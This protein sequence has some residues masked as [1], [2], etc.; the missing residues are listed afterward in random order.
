MKVFLNWIKTIF[1][2]IGRLVVEVI[3]VKIVIMLV[4]TKIYLDVSSQVGVIGFTLVIVG[5]LTV[6]G[7]RFTARYA[8]LLKQVKEP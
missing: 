8:N 6:L 2:R 3:S 4:I 1:E 7:L 5:W